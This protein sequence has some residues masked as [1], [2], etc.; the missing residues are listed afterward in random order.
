MNKN[1]EDFA[2]FFA[3]NE[4]V[5]I[6][7]MKKSHLEAINGVVISTNLMLTMALLCKN[8]F[9]G[10]EEDVIN[11]VGGI[12]DSSHELITESILGEVRGHNEINELSIELGGEGNELITKVRETLNGSLAEIKKGLFEGFK[13]T[14]EIFSKLNAQEKTESSSEGTPTNRGSAPEHNT[15][16]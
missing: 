3:T 11:L 16:S 2:K 13:K 4:K 10:N 1:M 8:I 5:L 14:C 12:I 9:K 6:E 7:D 15:V